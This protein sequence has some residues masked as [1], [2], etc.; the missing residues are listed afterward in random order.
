MIEV[1][2]L[3]WIAGQGGIHTTEIN[4]ETFALEALRRVIDRTEVEPETL[5]FHTLDGLLEYAAT[6]FCYEIP[7]GTGDAA[8]HVVGPK[9]VDLYAPMQKRIGNVRWK[10]AHCEVIE[11]AFAFGQWFCQEDF[12]VQLM[13][14]FVHDDNLKSLVGMVACIT[15]VQEEKKD[16][17]GI[18]PMI[19]IRKG[20][21]LR[22][23]KKLENPITLA[24]WRTFR[25]IEQPAGEFVIRI[26]EDRSR[27]VQLS[28]YEADGAQWKLEAIGRIGD[29]LTKGMDGPSWP[30]GF[31][32]R[33]FA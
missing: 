19:E 16:D 1:D 18:S 25:E 22:E 8:F 7:D 26:E 5:T 3:Q 6:Q 14:K 9:S 4:G 15:S 27:S 21:R 29:Y 30:A 2:A 31:T 11:D 28:L 10:Y 17:D 24:P 20:L 32:I 12:I 13:S 33:V 23:E